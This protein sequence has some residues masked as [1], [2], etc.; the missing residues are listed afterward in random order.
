MGTCNDSHVVGTTRV[1]YANAG[2]MVKWAFCQQH[3][4]APGAVSVV[5][6]G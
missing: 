1:K 5:Q 2:E 6:G 4:D 3:E